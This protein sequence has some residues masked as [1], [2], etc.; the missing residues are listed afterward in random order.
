M[1]LSHRTDEANRRVFMTIRGGATGAATARYIAELAAG[2][3]ELAGWD[4]IQD[5]RENDG[6][7]DNADIEAVSRAFGA[8]G[9]CWTVFVSHDPNLRLWCKVMDGMFAGRLH[10]SAPTPEAAVKALEEVRAGADLVVA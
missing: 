4:W 2:R 3:P 9:P 1:D 8:T 10:L 6:E 5:L 7:V